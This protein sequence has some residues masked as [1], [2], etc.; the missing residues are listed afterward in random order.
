[1]NVGR[2][3]EEN[4]IKKG[5]KRIN[6]YCKYEQM[7]LTRSTTLNLECNSIYVTWP[8]NARLYHVFITRYLQPTC[9]NRRRDHLQSK[10]QEY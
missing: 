3:N 6:W 7:Q 4:N 1:M 2:P 9:F 5:R 10:L 8:T